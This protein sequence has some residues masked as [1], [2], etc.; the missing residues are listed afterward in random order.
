MHKEN[1]D[2]PIEYTNQ[3]VDFFD[4]SQGQQDIGSQYY[5]LTDAIEKG[6]IVRQNS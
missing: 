1:F 5:T 4:Y 6:W 3:V 2:L